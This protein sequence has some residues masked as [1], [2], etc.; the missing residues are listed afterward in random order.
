MARFRGDTRGASIA[1]SHALSIGI[2]A[3]LV[4]GLLMGGSTLLEHQR[5]RVVEQGL[6]GV[7]GSIASDLLTLDEYPVGSLRSDLRVEGSFPSH[8]SGV[9][10]DVHLT[11]DP[12]GARLYLNATS[13][14]RHAV[15][16][17]ENETDVCESTVNGGDLVVAYDR[18]AECLEL[19]DAP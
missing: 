8:I 10:Y 9:R 19:R 11:G 7:G 5:Q 6:E 16:R 17:Y 13:L 15:V 3:L 1:V 12:G 18:N 4:T 2:T 14:D